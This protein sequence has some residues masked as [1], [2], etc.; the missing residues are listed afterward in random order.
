MNN[1]S[2]VIEK[3]LRGLYLFKESK[4]AMQTVV[5]EVKERAN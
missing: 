5:L 3:S 4:L 1:L 2:L